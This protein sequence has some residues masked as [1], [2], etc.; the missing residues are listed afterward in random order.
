[1]GKV[2][3]ALFFIA[4]SFLNAETVPPNVIIVYTDDQGSVDANC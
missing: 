3:G 4:A 1:M 2:L